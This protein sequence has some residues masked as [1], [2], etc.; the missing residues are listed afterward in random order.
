MRTLFGAMALVATFATMTWAIEPAPAAADP[1]NRGIAAEVKAVTMRAS[2]INGMKVIN[3]SGK[4]LGSVKDLV[5]DAANGKIRYAA[6]S[7][8]GFL[9]V[10]DKLFAVPWNQFRVQWDAGAK[11]YYLVLSLEEETLK[12]APGF[13]SAHWPDFADPQFTATLDKHYSGT[14]RK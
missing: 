4:E 9:G 13:D 12:K 2:D 6:L 10:G 8:G 3:N 11:K 5:L 14:V 7:Y 1:A